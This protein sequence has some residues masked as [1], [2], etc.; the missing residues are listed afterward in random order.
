MY[1]IAVAGITKQN[2]LL[3]GFYILNEATMY[4]AAIIVMDVLDAIRQQAL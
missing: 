1:L 4:V 2:Y 3:L